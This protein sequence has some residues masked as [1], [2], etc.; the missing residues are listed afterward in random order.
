MLV[1]LPQQLQ[2]DTGAAQLLVDNAGQ[3]VPV[4]DAS[5]GEIN[6]AQIFVAVLGASNYTYSCATPSQKAVDWVAS[7]IATLEFIGG[8][9]RLSRARDNCGNQQDRIM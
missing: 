6:Q 8:V 1:L 4:V 3:T 7:I 5:T 9:P 2:R